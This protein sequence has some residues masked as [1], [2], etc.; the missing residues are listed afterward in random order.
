MVCSS[1]GFVHEELCPIITDAFTEHLQS[2]W[3]GTRLADGVLFTLSAHVYV[4]KR[5]PH[6]TA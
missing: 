2:C 3:L 4:P 5:L 6:S 1:G